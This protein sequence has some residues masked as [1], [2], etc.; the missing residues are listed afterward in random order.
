MPSSR[1][2]ASKGCSSGLLRDAN[3]APLSG[4]DFGEHEPVGDVEGI[5][6]L[7][8]PE[9]DRQRLLR[10]DDLGPGEARA[11]V[12][13]TDDIGRSRGWREEYVARQLMQVDVA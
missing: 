13:Q 3:S 5:D 12:D 8:R 1:S 6:H 9:H 2:M 7:Q 10:S 11:A 4:Q